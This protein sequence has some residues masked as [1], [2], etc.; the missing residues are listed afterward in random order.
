MTT[1]VAELMSSAPYFA[2][3]FS[4]CETMFEQLAWKAI[5][6]KYAMGEVVFLE[7]V[8]VES[9]TNLMTVAGLEPTE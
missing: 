1:P 5:Q 3:L 7:S 6:R 4:E 8:L 2:R 9:S